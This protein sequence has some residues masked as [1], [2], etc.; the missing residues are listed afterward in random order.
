MI[1]APQRRVRMVGTAQGIKQECQ[2]EASLVIGGGTFVRNARECF[3]QAFVAHFFG[4]LAVTVGKRE[5]LICAKNDCRPKTVATADTFIPFLSIFSDA[6]KTA[7]DHSSIIGRNI[8]KRAVF[9]T[10][11]SRLLPN[12]WGLN[13]SM[14][15]EC[16]VGIKNVRFFRVH[17]ESKNLCGKHRVS[18]IARLIDG[19]IKPD[20]LTSA[21]IVLGF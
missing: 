4:G 8:S 12:G 21:S 15:A 5:D 7:R 9:G 16:I 13:R 2:K 17:H 6:V 11:I 1:K 18:R 14:K 3:C 10:V 20:I 19:K